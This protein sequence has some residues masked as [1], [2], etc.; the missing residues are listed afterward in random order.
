MSLAVGQQVLRRIFTL[1]RRIFVG[2]KYQLWEADP[3][4]G[5]GILIKAWPFLRDDPSPVERNL[6]DRELRILYRLAST[7]EAERRLV[8]LIDAA[9]DRDAQA[10]VLA[11]KV[12][13]LDRLSDVL[14]DRR[15]YGWLSDMSDISKRAALWRGALRLI[16]GLAH[17][18]RFRSVHRALKL[19][20]VFLDSRRGPDSLRLG[21]FEWSV[22]LGDLMRDESRSESPVGRANASLNADWC[23]LGLVLSGLFGVA[24]DVV[25][26]GDVQRVVRSIQELPRLTEDE[27]SYLRSLLGANGHGPLDGDDIAHGCTEIINSLER[28]ASL[29]PGDHLGVVVVLRNR[30]GPTDFAVWIADTDPS[31]N[32]TD[33]AALRSSIQDDISDAEIVSS[34]EAEQRSYFLKGRL[35]PYRLFQFKRNLPDG[36]SELSWNLGYLS[37]AEYLDERRVTKRAFS[38]PGVIRVFTVQD[39]HSSYPEICKTVRPWESI[40]PAPPEPTGEAQAQIA[41]LTKFLQVTN[42][43]ER[44]IRKTEI[45]PVRLVRQWA[46]SVH[47]YA[48]V[49]E[50][51][52]TERLAMYDPRNTP[53][54]TSYLSD[55]DAKGQ[56]ETEVYL[57]TE[58]GT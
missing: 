7:P 10:F 34:G 46:D 6:W 18:H 30:L 28:P 44:A 15:R 19:E 38:L 21:G 40:L 12:P 20:N 36:D 41:F 3:G 27:K 23:D 14:A 42:E 13:G 51:T 17:V 54:L 9:V 16:E 57:G 50:C 26:T 56:R 2:P 55:E 52:R 11:L 4:D 5:E 8:T 35:R 24:H 29:R 33:E 37:K 53:S 1:R 31:V 39:A 43:I 25:S 22:R 47:E 32:A 45:Y 48:I 58:F 49:Q